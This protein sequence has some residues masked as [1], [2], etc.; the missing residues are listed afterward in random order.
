MKKKVTE[1][2]KGKVRA[3]DVRKDL[4]KENLAA[5]GAVTL[6][7]NDVEAM[8][9][10]LLCV[11]MNI[12]PD[13][14][15][16]LTTRING[17]DGVIALLKFSFGKM[18]FLAPAVLKLTED[19]LGAASQC[20]GDRDTII[21]SRVID[22]PQGIAEMAFR[23]D[24]IEEVLITED[25][26]N[27]L[28]DHIHTLYLEIRE[29]IALADAMHT[30]VEVGHEDKAG[31]GY[32]G[33]LLRR[34]NIRLA[35]MDEGKPGV[36]AASSLNFVREQGAEST[37]QEFRDA[38]SRYQHYQNQRK[39]LPPLPVVRDQPSDAEAREHARARLQA[40]LRAQG[41]KSQTTE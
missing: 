19:T 40:S 11:C 26:L 1:R 6:A 2:R 12:N 41:I 31:E 20:K 39:S 8:L 14:W 18:F 37:L 13:A 15:R 24:K 38:M 30:A 21:H 7:W 3:Y 5:L 17:I 33:R 23:R 10:V 25:A 34:Y 28:Y 29:L 22:V 36:I 16:E 4:T 35:I 27:K 32:A 9:D